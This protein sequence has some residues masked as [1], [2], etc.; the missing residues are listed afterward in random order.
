MVAVVPMAEA[1]SM[2]ADTGNELP[3][4]KNNGWRQDAASRFSC[5]PSMFGSYGCK[6][7]H[8]LMEVKGSEAQ[9]R[10]VL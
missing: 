1:V 9:G 2:V 10:K 8:N 7:R 3:R 4:K 6:S 5:T